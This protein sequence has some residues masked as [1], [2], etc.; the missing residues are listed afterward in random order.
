[1]TVSS[2]LEHGICLVELGRGDEARA[3]LER[4]RAMLVDR[5]GADDPRTR[6]ADE[7]LAKL[8]R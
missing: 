6:K 2:E 1:M 7:A 4:A 5:R 8:D 3:Q